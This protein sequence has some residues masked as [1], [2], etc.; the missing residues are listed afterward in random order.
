[1]VWFAMMFLGCGGGADDPFSGCPSGVE[2]GGGCCANAAEVCVRDS[3]GNVGCA[4][5][6]NSRGDC[7][8]GCC[9][10][11]G[12]GAG[13]I[14]GP[15]VCQ[16]SNACCFVGICPGTSCC[17]ADD[18]DNQFCAEECDGP[19]D[20]GGASTCQTF[21]FSHTTCSGPRACGPNN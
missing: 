3:G 16:A 9:A 13:N 7:A 14:V 8:S 18:N 21:D 19:A 2:C 15:Y 20:C 1:M 17:V 6:C 12:D 11:L 4:P 5:S 10:P